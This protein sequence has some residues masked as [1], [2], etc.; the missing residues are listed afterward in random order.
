MK[1]TRLA[2][3]NV[4]RRPR[5][6]N[7][8]QLQRKNM[9]DGSSEAEEITPSQYYP[10][11]REPK[12]ISKKKTQVVIMGEL[13]QPSAPPEP[14]GAR[15]PDSAKSLAIEVAALEE[16]QQEKQSQEER[17]VEPEK[18]TSDLGG[19]SYRTPVRTPTLERG[20]RHSIAQDVLDAMLPLITGTGHFD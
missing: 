12:E 16:E 15:R 3:I 19:P 6:P 14:S 4:R 9:D 7:V 2:G 8:S 10:V 17:N 1:Q 13:P 11:K 5:L 18:P 20:N